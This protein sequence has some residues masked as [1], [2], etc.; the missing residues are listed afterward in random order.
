MTEQKQLIPFVDRFLDTAARVEM[1]AP[2]GTITF[3]DIVEAEPVKPGEIPQVGLQ[4]KT[5]F[6]Q[7]ENYKVTAEYNQE[8]ANDLLRLHGL[9]AADQTKSSIFNEGLVETQLQLLR[10][11]RAEGIKHNLSRRTK[12]ETFLNKWFKLD[13][14]LYVGEAGVDRKILFLSNLIASASR[15]GPANFVVVNTQ[16]LAYIQDSVAFTFANHAAEEMGGNIRYVGNLNNIMV[17]IDPYQKFSDTS[18]LIGRITRPSEPGAYFTE[19]SREFLELD[20][21]GPES[22][23]RIALSSRHSIVTTENSTTNYW[24]GTI[25]P[26]KKP[27]WR[28][29][30]GI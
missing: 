29:L 27:I 1:N 13:F 16:L 23:K 6:V 10:T 22:K 19:Y 20:I 25:I 24:T 3:L 7:A 12:W 14:P 30:L 9:S 2:N 28:K 18:I 5:K 17:F 15:R 21:N 11:Y 26:A 8:L 4:A